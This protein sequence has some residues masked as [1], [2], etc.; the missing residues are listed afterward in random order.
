[1]N[2]ELE[3]RLDPETAKVLDG[4]L[5]RHEESIHV[6]FSGGL[7]DRFASILNYYERH[8]SDA[9]A[10][11]KRMIEDT[12]T[13]LRA[14]KMLTETIGMAGTHAEKAA[15]L[16]GMVELLDSAIHKLREEQTDNVLNNWPHFRWG[17]FS[18][19]P[20]YVYIN[21]RL[22]ELNYETLTK[23]IIKKARWRFHTIKP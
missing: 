14:F 3:Q 20:F 17:A 15:R 4:Y 23:F 12:I 1:M 16:R 8:A 9:T 11:R 13:Y 10:E 18:D 5:K 7:F 21:K 2:F 22:H 6:G 19:Y